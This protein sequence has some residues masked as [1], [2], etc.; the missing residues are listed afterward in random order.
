MEK[1]WLK[2]YPPGVP[3][4]LNTDTYGSLVE[5]FDSYSK[6][7]SQK[8]AFSNFGVQLTYQEMEKLTR[9]FAAFLRHQLKMKKSERFAIMLPNVLQFPIAMIGALR[10]GLIVVNVNPLY[11]APELV[12][13]LK[14]SG[15]TGIIVLENFANE[16]SKALPET[17]VKHVIV[18]KMGDCLG[19]VKGSLINFVVKRI[20]K[21]VPDWNI[22]EALHFKEVMEGAESLSLESINI[23][24]E[25][26]AF[27]QY[28]G[29]TTG[30]SKGAVLTHRNVLSNVMQCLAWFK[31]D[32]VPGKEV[33][34]TALP[35]YHIFSLT[36][37]CFCF[38]TVGSECVLITNP[39]EMKRMI[40]EIRKSSPTIFAGLN[41][42]FKGMLHHPS[43]SKNTFSNLKV[44]I[45]G[46][47]AL[48]KSVAEEW[49]KKTGS[50]IIEGYGLTEASP[51]VSSNPFEPYK[52]QRQYRFAATRYGRG[53]S[54]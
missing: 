22:P 8:N 13:Q 16:L 32:L 2:S 49:K 53:Y 48:Q 14:D 50:T 1:I 29:G 36:V 42:L 47:M 5:A 10:A 27:L 21:M 45:G 12:Y 46:G 43:F 3:E 31:Q 19:V 33:V 28:T 6:Q 18:T 35:L 41:T 11:T 37:C 54:R 7:F 38:M 23:K 4:T 24:G 30:L 40:K 9:N 39:R 20:K 34:L 44:V 51:V 17:D 25:D 15:A 26:P 52:L